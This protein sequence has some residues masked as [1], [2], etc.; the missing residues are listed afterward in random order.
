MFCSDGLSD[1]VSLVAIEKVLA[2]KISNQETFD[3]VAKALTAG[4]KD[5]ITIIMVS[6][7]NQSIQ[8][9]QD[10]YGSDDITDSTEIRED[11]RTQSTGD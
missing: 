5:N 4:G 9:D 10:T 3:R 11:D 7:P 2:R 1:P 6:A 8:A